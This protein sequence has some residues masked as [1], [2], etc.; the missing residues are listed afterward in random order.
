M[1]ELLPSLVQ[2]NARDIARTNAGMQS[3]LADVGDMAD[4]LA[5]ILGEDQ[6]ADAAEEFSLS[7]IFAKDWKNAKMRGGKSKRKGG[8][9]F[10]HGSQSS[11]MRRA[12]FTQESHASATMIADDGT[13][14]KV[15]D[16][17]VVAAA[18]ASAEEAEQARNEALQAAKAKVDKLKKQVLK[19]RGQVDETKEQLA[20][21]EK[22][23]EEAKS[24]VEVL[25]AECKAK[26]KTLKLVPDSKENLRKL[27]AIVE[28]SRAKLEAA[29]AK[30]EQR[31][32][33]FLDAMEEKR[34]SF[35]QRKETANELAKGLLLFGDCMIGVF[36]TVTFD[37]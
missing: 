12:E 30:W 22:D 4:T 7:S 17:G 11:L 18:A 26:I 2:L 9:S 14:L 27:E 28:E 15:D 13:V 5:Q 36:K 35:E 23:L 19:G 34:M 20:K 21:T 3:S 37:G 24:S 16:S 32:Q 29:K 25:T 33:A 8:D 10:A 1:D 31:K 6:K